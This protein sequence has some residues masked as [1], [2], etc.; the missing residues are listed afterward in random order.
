[1][2]KRYALTARSLFHRSALKIEQCQFSFSHVTADKSQLISVSSRRKEAEGVGRRMA[3]QLKVAFVPPLTV[4][5][6]G[7]RTELDPA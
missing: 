3:D 1:M 7:G 5:W 2:G 4:H 6:E